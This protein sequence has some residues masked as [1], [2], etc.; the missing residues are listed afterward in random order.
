MAR[1]IAGTTVSIFLLA[2]VDQGRSQSTNAPV[3]APDKARLDQTL[4][5]LDG[6]GS[7]IAAAGEFLVAGCEEGTIQVWKK[8]VWM[9]VRNGG[10]APVVLRGH[11]GPVL[12]LALHGTKLASAGADGKVVFWDL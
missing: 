9:G 4:I 2:V 7:S 5:G 8:D 3:F 11:H 6:P 1:V 10:K 12:A